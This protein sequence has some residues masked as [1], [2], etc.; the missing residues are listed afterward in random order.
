[1]AGTSYTRQSSLTDGDTITASL[2]NDEY[3]QLVNAFAYAAAGT[4]GHQHDGGAG[5]GG[6]IEIIGDQDFKNKIVVDSTNNRW[7]IFVEVGGTAVEQVRIEDGVVYPVTD[8]DVDLGTECIARFKAA[9]I[10]SITAT[11]SLTL[12]T[13]ITVSS[14]LDE[15]DMVSNSATALATQQSIKAYVDSQ[16][17]A[18]DLDLTDGTTSI[19]IDLDSESLSVLGGTGIDSTASGNGV[20]LAIDS[21]VAT[22]TGTQTLSNKTLATPV[23]S[24]NL[25]TDGT[26]DGRDVAAD[27]AKL[28]TVETNADVTDTANVTAA[29]ALMDS[30]L[31]NITAVKAIDQGV[32]T[33]DSPSFV[34]LTASGEITANGGIALGDSD[35]VTF[36]AGDD[37]QIYHDGSNSYIKDA[38][39]GGL[40]LLADADTA[41]RAADNSTARAIFGG[42]VKLY[43]SG[44]QKLATTSTGIDVTGEIT[45]DALTINSSGVQIG[46]VLQS[47]STTSARLALMDANTT[48]ASQ[49]GIGATGNTLG[50]YASGGL[51]KV[52]VSD[53]GIDVTGTVVA[54]GL[55]LEPDTGL[56]QTDAA[57]SSYSTSNGV[58]LNGHAGGWLSLRGDGTGYARWTMFGGATGD[59]TLHTNN[60]QRI[61]VQGSTGDVSFYEDTGTT[62]KM[63]WSASSETLTVDGVAQL[64]TVSIYDN[65][66]NA[67]VAADSG[68]DLEL[69]GRSGQNVNVYAN[70][71]LNT[72]FSSTGIDVTGTATMDGLVVDG[73]ANFNSNNVVHT[74]P[75][76][77]YVLSESDVVDENT[78]FLQASG[79]LR[80]RT[81]DDAGSNVAERMRIDHGTG[82]ISFYEDTGTTAKLKW[83]A[84]AE[85]LTTSGLT[86]AGPSTLTSGGTT[87]SIDRTGGS[88][89][90]VELKQASVLRG[91][92][93]ADSTKSL[94][95]FNGS[96][97]ER[98]SV[99]NTGIDV[100][101]T[102]TMDGLTVDGAAVVRAGN[103]LTLNRTDN[104]IGGAMSYVAG[105]GFIFND[106]NGDG[107]SFNVGAANRMRIDTAGN[108]GI[109]TSSPA[110]KLN[111]AGD[112]IADGEGNTRSIGFDF[113]GA[114]K[115]NLYMDGSTDADKM[116]IRKGTTNVATFD[117]SGNVG[118][119][120]SSPTDALVV[121]GNVASPHRIKV[122]NANASGKAALN[123]TQGTTVK[124]WLEF[125]NA[126]GIFDVWQ[127]TNNDLRFGTNNTE[128]M[129]ID[130]SGNL[131]VGK[132]SAN[133]TIA[134]AQMESNGVI[135]ATVNNNQPMFANRLSSDGSIFGFY[136]DGTTVGSIQSGIGGRLALGHNDT[137][138]YFADDLDAIVPWNVTANAVRDSA[139]DLGSSGTNFRFKD[140][141]LS[142]GVYL[143]GTGAAN[144]L[145]DYEEGTWTP[146][147]GGGATATNMSGKYTKV[148]NLVTA[149]LI[150]ENSTI[151]G[152]PD[153]IVSGLPFTSVER[154]PLSVTYYRTFNTACE[155]LGGFLTGNGNTMQFVGMVQGGNWVTAPL[156]AGSTR[157]LFATAVY[158]A[159]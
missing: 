139:I 119:G 80:I 98:F 129:R 51:P 9:Y 45:A 55:I 99:S 93:G 61:K 25:T 103:T 70:G 29:G 97:A 65:G 120:T 149:Y 104:A 100:T 159:A 133:Y 101:G 82:D 73:T 105:T 116:H 111:V 6:N 94:I 140:L 123:F 56:Y 40:R 71:A 3:N 136:K 131:L 150:F 75:T 134:G 79:S 2:F 127:Y 115:Y 132:T 81:V 106:A 96:A 128:R 156:T 108:V 144:K 21:T 146:T 28:D 39:T 49:V 66:T 38:G 68:H 148:G 57:L 1:M 145:D 124:S 107:T 83:D 95:V 54:D 141:Y 35:K 34:G 137:G 11:T 143:G 17:T 47:T 67:T 84:S 10:D 155:S 42:D 64:G 5:E 15:D 125:D 48:A 113:Y 59:A 117:S 122:S 78:Q 135:G 87:L 60:K 91:Y 138:L 46:T 58:Y 152:T 157:Y 110:Y 53:T 77:N 89:A 142:G 85:M 8:S 23:I 92:L 50:L 62:A 41:I 102:A 52:V 20:T 158:Q 22:L 4:T 44:N 126:T 86:V 63:V 30:E 43:H 88:T 27:G 90:L 74:S 147:L 7:S 32:A 130:S 121:E 151:S 14:I 76:P 24:G 37:L 118:I 33:T 12:G 154:T 153:Y 112:I 26:I 36:G 16:V 72:T 114:L 13:S 69:R 109:G 18:Q 19:S 31:T